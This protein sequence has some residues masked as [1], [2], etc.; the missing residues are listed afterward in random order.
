MK[1]KKK[2]MAVAV[3]AAASAIAGCSGTTSSNVVPD[4]PSDDTVTIVAQEG[5][6]LA[7]TMMDDA[8]AAQDALDQGDVYTA[9]SY[10][11]TIR[12]NLNRIDEITFQLHE[13]GVNNEHLDKTAYA[14]HEDFADA[15]SICK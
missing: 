12:K 4:K 1:H 2:A 10:I 7:A 9:C 15:E 8:Q 11:G 13:L 6:D 3:L 14:M 5:Y